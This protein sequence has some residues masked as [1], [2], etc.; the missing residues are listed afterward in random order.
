MIWAVLWFDLSI[1]RNKNVLLTYDRLNRAL[2][3]NIMLKKENY[4]FYAVL[5][6]NVYVAARLLP[7]LSLMDAD[8]M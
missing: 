4:L 2:R 3:Y 5:N 6:L 8:G 1:I 7:A